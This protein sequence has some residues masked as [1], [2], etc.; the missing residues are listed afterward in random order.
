MNNDYGTLDAETQ[1]ILRSL[2]RAAG[3]LRRG[4]ALFF[5]ESDRRV[6]SSVRAES[7]DSTAS[8][9]LVF[10]LDH[11]ESSALNT[12][13]GPEAGQGQLLLTAMRAHRLGLTAGTNGP[14]VSITLPPQRIA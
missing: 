5:F 1:R 13:L 6:E 14:D 7:L 4:Q 8:G 12:V 11:A 10:S 3:D 9:L 2:D